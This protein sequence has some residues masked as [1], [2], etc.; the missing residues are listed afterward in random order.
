MSNEK[1]QF[2]RIPFNGT[3]RLHMDPEGEDQTIKM[4]DVTLIDVSLK[5]ALIEA[6]AAATLVGGS[7]GSLTLKLGLEEE[8]HMEVELARV[9]GN[10]AGLRVHGIDLDS[11]TH[12][13]RLIASNL[14]DASML[15]R[16]M[17]ALLKPLMAP[18]S[19]SE[20]SCV[21]RRHR[22]RCLFGSDLFLF[23]RAGSPTAPPSPASPSAAPHWL[24]T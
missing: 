18:P 5:G 21:P 2:S 13:R 22:P 3:A 24:T 17:M 15:D 10:I 20:V 16:D 7:R 8:I 9:Q 11:I 14:G 4:L 6:P 12:L 23:V 19:P 1:R